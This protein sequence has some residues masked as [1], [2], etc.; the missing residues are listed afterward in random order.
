MN[1]NIESEKY[2]LIPNKAVQNINSGTEDINYSFVQLYG[3]R[4]ITYL[5]HLIELQN[6]HEDI[7][8][9]INMILWKMKIKDNV[10]KE[11]QYFKEFL[12][13]I[14]NDSLF[15]ISDN[16][17]LQNISS[18]DFIIGKL[19]IYDYEKNKDNNSQ[20]IKYF[21]LL[22]SEY[23]KIVNEYYGDLDR[24]NL[25]NLFCNIKSRIKKNAS[26]VFCSER[27]PEVCYPSYDVI[28]SD[29]FI[30]SDK[31]LKQYIDELV[32]LDLIRFDCAGDMILKAEGK[33]P[34]RRKAN[35]TY[36]LYKDGWEEELKQAISMF[37]SQKR[38]DGWSFLTKQEE[39]SSNDKR[40]IT[41]KINTLEKVSK[42]RTLS[43]YE[44]KELKQLKK[45]QENWKIKNNSE[46]SVQE[47]KA[48]PD[49]ARE[50]QEIY[51]LMDDLGLI[52]EN[53]DDNPLSDFGPT[54]YVCDYCKEE[55]EIKIYQE[56]NLCDH[57]IELGKHKEIDPDSW[58]KNDK[59]IENDFIN[60]DS[61][62]DYDTETLFNFL[63]FDALDL[64]A[65]EIA[66][67]AKHRMTIKEFFEEVY[68]FAEYSD[69]LDFR[70]KKRQ[71]SEEDSEYEYPF[72]DISNPKN[73]NINKEIDLSTVNKECIVCGDKFV[74][75]DY[76]GNWCPKCWK[77][78]SNKTKEKEVIYASID[79]LIEED[80]P[81]Q[82]E[83]NLPESLK[84]TK[85]L[86]ADGIEEN[87]Y[88][89][90]VI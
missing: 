4:A 51:E 71:E 47:I 54:I 88:E 7:H 89:G 80:E 9:S 49:R 26:D 84:V 60:N 32:K 81:D 20:K 52:A 83:S 8:M 29:I 53:E 41:Q 37:R 19:N 56:Y 90:I 43:Q 39:I 86:V 21:L 50:D 74:V 73:N 72:K 28:K 33:E 27:L 36:A 76:S 25:L 77:K 24:Y 87:P 64:Y 15:S 34:I 61:S 1:D 5:K 31:T 68:D 10:Q 12:I 22:E 79:D 44:K 55:Y 35:F 63:P 18:N 70:N 57:C 45:K 40:S 42:N 17:N 46:T 78:K 30:E 14:H 66:E 62:N 3:K 11:R 16:I 38:K 65:D 82:D 58:Y 23:N 59:S 13:A 6:I 48:K 67:I 85:Q 75:N 2:V 69:F